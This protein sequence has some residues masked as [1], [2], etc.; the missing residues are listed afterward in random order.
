[1]SNN[2][3]LVIP[4]GSK[5]MALDAIRSLWGDLMAI[6]DECVRCRQH[7]AQLEER[8]KELEAPKEIGNVVQLSEQA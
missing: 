4:A 6:T 1:M 2:P 7:I 5:A 3:H 8:I